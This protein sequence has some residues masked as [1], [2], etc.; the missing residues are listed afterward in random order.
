MVAPEPRPAGRRRP[1]PLVAAAGEALDD[2]GVRWALLRGERDLADPRGDV[3]IL[4]DGPRD[5]RAVRRALRPLGIVAAPRLG[6]GAHRHFWG[7]HR[8]TDRWIELDVEWALDFGPQRHFALNWLAPAL[9]SGAAR[10]VLDRRRRSPGVPGVRLLHPDDGFWAL[11][12]HVIVDKA[13]VPA[14]HAERLVE[15]SV[16]A[17]AGSPLATVVTATCP[18]GWDAGRVIGCVRG[19][20]WPA[21]LELGDV[22]R[23]RAYARRPVT[24]RARALVRGLRRLGLALGPALVSRGITVEVVGPDG[25]GRSAVSA[26]LVREQP[27]GARLVP[28]GRRGRLVVRFH[29]LRGRTVV[30][31]RPDTDR[32]ATGPRPDLVIVVDP[33]D[34]PVQGRRPQD[35]LADATAVVW[36]ARTGHRPAPTAAATTPG[37]GTA[38]AG[39][40]V[41]G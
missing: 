17:T 37:S 24:H 12:L 7:Y 22:L 13:A 20:D 40:R 25:T 26:G 38:A 9:R 41:A 34:P 23:R 39:N 4:V 11:L 30:L 35:V 6:A 28:P 21:L 5:L 14:R 33:P 8:P 15:L 19:G 16:H 3:D 36:A 18:P 27:L 29:R 1:H 31:D 2:A 32:R 10:A